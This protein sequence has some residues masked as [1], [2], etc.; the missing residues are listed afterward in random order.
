VGQ[1]ENPRL[2]PDGQRL[3]LTVLQTGYDVWVLDVTRDTMTRLTFDA[4][5]DA[6]PLWSADA[7]RVFFTSRRAGPQDIFWKLADGSGDAEQLTAGAYRVPTSVS[8]DGKTLVFRE[9][10]M[11]GDWDIGTVSVDGDG[12]PE[13][14]LD[15]PFSEHS[16]MLSPDDRW[17]AYVSDESG[18]D[19]VY[20][21]SFPDAGGKVQVST[22]GGIEPMWSRDGR[23]LFYRNRYRMMAVSVT[24]EPE[25]VLGDPVMLFEEPY[26]LEGG[27]PNANYDVAADGRFVMI[28]VTPAEATQLH[29]VRNWSEELKLLA[30]GN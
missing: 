26:A 4:A 6:R 16:G 23:E 7:E 22:E 1:Y 24:E 15:T 10:S 14:F 29:V 19:E 28:G 3:A 2:S 11:G 21:R 8:S 13:V 18:R 9:Q 12:E 30:P 27:N 17:L 25:L 5:S 20:V